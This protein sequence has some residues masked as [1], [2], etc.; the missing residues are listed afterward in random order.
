[1]VEFIGQWS[2]LDVFVVILLSALGKFGSLLDIT[3]GPGAVAFGA[4]V[5][6]TMVAAMGF[7][8][9]LAWRLAGH[10]R[11]TPSAQAPGQ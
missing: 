3:P 8:P 2:M 9:R 7:D 4:V 10:R 6:M 1:M 5:V 11:H